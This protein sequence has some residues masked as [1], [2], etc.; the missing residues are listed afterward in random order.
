MYKLNLGQYKTIFGQYKS[1]LG[2]YKTPIRQNQVKFLDS[3][4]WFFQENKL[5]FGFVQVKI[6][7]VQD[8]FYTVQVKIGTV[9][10]TDLTKSFEI[11]GQY[12]VIFSTK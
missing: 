1:K 7:T 9:Q 8:D 11:L 12:M 4:W 10:D 5:H 2:Q 3:T 6:W